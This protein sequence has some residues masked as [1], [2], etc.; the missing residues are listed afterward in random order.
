MLFVN[1]GSFLEASTHDVDF[2]LVAVFDY[3]TS[4]IIDVN[5]RGFFVDDKPT[6]WED[7]LIVIDIVF[8]EQI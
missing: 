4:E 6:F 1:D 3:D 5:I 2:W 8:E 7:R